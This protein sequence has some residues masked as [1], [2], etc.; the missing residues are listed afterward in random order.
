M[1]IAQELVGASKASTTVRRIVTITRTE[2]TNAEI[3]I[4]SVDILDTLFTFREALK[5]KC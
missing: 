1:A 4:F 5:N 2:A 3:V